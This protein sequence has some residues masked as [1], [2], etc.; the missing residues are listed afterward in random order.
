MVSQAGLAQVELPFES[1]PC[2]IFQRSAAIELV[3][4][5]AFCRDECKLDFVGHRGSALPIVRLPARRCEMTAAVHELSAKLPHNILRQ[6]PYRG[7]LLETLARS[8]DSTASR[9]QLL[10]PIRLELSLT[11]FSKTE[12]PDHGGQ[13]HALA[14]KRH[15]DY[16]KR[17][18]EN[19]IAIGE[20]SAIIHCEWDGERRG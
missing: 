2:L 5:L 16:R 7:K 4:P 6:M 12:H 19:E 17:E 15:Q 3:D 14:D 1:A 20:W 18:E 8:L 10:V 11:S 13:R 9:Q